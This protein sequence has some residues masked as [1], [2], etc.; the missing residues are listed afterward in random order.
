[1]VD[2]EP[3]VV[4]TSVAAAVLGQILGVEGGLT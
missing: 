3:I 1:M 2:D 4:A